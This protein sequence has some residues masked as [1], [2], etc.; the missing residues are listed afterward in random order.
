MLE[1]TQPQKVVYAVNTDRAFPGYMISTSVVLRQL[2]NAMHR[3]QSK[4]NSLKLEDIAVTIT[5]RPVQATPL[6][7]ASVATQLL[8]GSQFFLVW[9]HIRLRNAAS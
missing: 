2:V 7:V 4:L 3:F 6:I 8:L 5:V 9:Q 1:E